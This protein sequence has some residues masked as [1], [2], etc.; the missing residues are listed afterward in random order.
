MDSGETATIAC[1]IGVQQG[2]PMGPAISLGLIR[3]TADTVRSFAFLRREL[4]DI[5]TMVNPGKTIAYHRKGTSQRRR[6]RSWKAL[7]FASQAKE[8]RRW[9]VSRSARTNTCWTEQWR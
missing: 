4:G 7:M 3:I 1:S 9:W 8:G 6:F 2:D 5:G